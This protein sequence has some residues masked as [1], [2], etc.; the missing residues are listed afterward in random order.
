MDILAHVDKPQS[1]IRLAK[2]YVL[3]GIYSIRGDKRK[4]FEN[5][6]QLTDVHSIPLDNLNNLK[7]DPVFANLRNDQEY[8]KIM[9]ELEAKYQAEYERVKKWLEENGKL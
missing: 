1:Y 9:N 7:N 3:A 6:R 2:Y 5:L 4:A 8:I